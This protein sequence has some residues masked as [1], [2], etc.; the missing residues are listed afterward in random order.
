MINKIGFNPTFTGFV[1]FDKA[2]RNRGC[3]YNVTINSNSVSTI[4]DLEDSVE[5]SLNNGDV[6][7]LK[8]KN[9]L[10]EFYKA[11]VKAFRLAEGSSNVDG[12]KTNKHIDF[13]NF[14]NG[15]MTY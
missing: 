2:K 8:N 14:S 11:V 4:T 13:D 10:K 6:L 9:N 7:T 5:I 1:S 15:F 3:C 12:I